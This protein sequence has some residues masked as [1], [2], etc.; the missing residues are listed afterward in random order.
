[1]RVSV[2]RPAR[3]Q[4]LAFASAFGIAHGAP[5]VR[6]PTAIARDGANRLYLANAEPGAGF[7]RVVDRRGRFVANLGA[8]SVAAPQGVAVDRFDRVFVADTGSDRLLLYGPVR[9]GAVPLEAFSSASMHAPLALAFAPGSL[10]Y[11]LTPDR[12]VRLRYDDADRDGVSDSGDNCRGLANGDQDDT[13]SDG[14]GNACDGDDD[15]DGD[16][17]DAD[18]CPTE[19]AVPD[20]NNDGCRDPSTRISSPVQGRSYE[21]APT[22]ISGRSSGGSF[23]VQSVEVALG[24]RLDRR[25]PDAAGARCAWLVPARR[26]FVRGTCASPRFFPA[27]GADAWR[28]N[29]PSGLLDRGSYAVA[30]RAKQVNGPLESVLAYG[31]NLRVF[32]VR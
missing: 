22:R 21:P 31:R 26:A 27:T 17:D 29:I 13:D 3:A 20:A 25:R 5:P 7:I 30:A 11:A 6:V 19:R 32:S 10:L 4:T 24:R 1:M 15:G 8:G 14:R 2:F 9:S 23:G 16:A 12:V 18:R 28:V